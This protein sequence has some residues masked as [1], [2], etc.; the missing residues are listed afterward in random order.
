M[1]VVLAD[2]AQLKISKLANRMSLSTSVV[3]T[4]SKWPFTLH[5]CVN[6]INFAPGTFAAIGHTL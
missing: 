1:K 4:A 6:L 3:K 2:I 5:L